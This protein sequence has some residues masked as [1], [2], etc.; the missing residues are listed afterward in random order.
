MVTGGKTIK[1][2]LL[3]QDLKLFFFP[4]YQA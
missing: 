3:W 2:A 1:L 4:A